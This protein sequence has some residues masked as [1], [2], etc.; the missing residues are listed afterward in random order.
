MHRH[1]SSGDRWTRRH[2]TIFNSSVRRN[3]A[4]LVRLPD[5][6]E[7]WVV[8]SRYRS[9]PAAGLCVAASAGARI[10]SMWRYVPRSQWLLDRRHAWLMIEQ[11]SVGVITP[12]CAKLINIIYVTIIWSIV[13]KHRPMLIGIKCV[14]HGTKVGRK[15]MRCAAFYQFFRTNRLLT[16]DRTAR[17]N[18]YLRP[19]YK[20]GLT[21]TI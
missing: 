8:R 2:A 9:L 7:K 20:H 21:I 4:L 3:G 11:S 16:S 12:L 13:C 6:D 10:L 18:A 19:T 15:L 14:R 17:L 1:P 5:I